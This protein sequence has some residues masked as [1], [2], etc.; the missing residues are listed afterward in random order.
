MGL[1]VITVSYAV[2]AFRMRTDEYDEKVILS[3]AGVALAIVAFVMT[4]IAM[5]LATTSKAQDLIAFY[6]YNAPVYEDAIEDIRAGIVT[7]EGSL[8][9]SAN[10]RQIESYGLV[11][12][13]QRKAIT[14]FNAALVQHR[15]WEKSIWVGFLWA[16]VPEQIHPIPVLL[17][18]GNSDA[19]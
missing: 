16:N 8:F 17:S 1:I 7:S 5:P 9:D 14:D 18:G 10:H 4:S 19:R 2:L 15:R 6:S 12:R 11:I 13:D 3:V